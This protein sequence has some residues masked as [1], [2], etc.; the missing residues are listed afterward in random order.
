ML[1]GIGH[2]QAAR[3]RSPGA[4]GE[5]NLDPRV[6][7]AALH[8]PVGFRHGPEHYP[9]RHAELVGEKREGGG[10]LLI[11]ADRLIVVEEVRREAE[12]A[13]A[14]KILTLAL[15]SVAERAVALELL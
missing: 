1:L 2:E 11:V 14:R 8:D 5:M 10:V 13:V 4:V 15:A 7:V 3:N 12:D 6:D 9:C